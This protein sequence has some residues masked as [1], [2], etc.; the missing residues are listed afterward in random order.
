MMGISLPANPGCPLSSFFPCVRFL[1]LISC[2]ARMLIFCSAGCLRV[3]NTSLGG[4]M[5][6]EI[7]DLAIGYRKR[8]IVRHG[9]FLSFYH[10]EI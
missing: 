8:G 9:R 5:G 7:E 10:P 4:M 3:Q 1:D 2:K 6:F